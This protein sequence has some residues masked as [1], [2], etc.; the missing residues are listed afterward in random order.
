MLLIFMSAVFAFYMHAQSPSLNEV[1]SSDNQSFADEDGSFEDW[2]EIYNPSDQPVSLL[3]WYLSDDPSVPDKWQFPDVT[4]GAGAHL[5]VWAS[6]K[7]RRPPTRSPSALLT[8]IPDNAAW[9]YQDLGLPAPD[10]W[11]TIDFDD[12]DWSSGPGMLGY[13]CTSVN[14]TLS[15]GGVPDNKYITYYLRHTF[16]V[17]LENDEINDTG[18]FKLWADD[19]A[20][21]YLNGAEI[22]RV[23]IAPGNVN[24][25]TPASSVVA[26]RG[27][28]E[29]F[30]VSLAAIKTGTNV[31]SV[32][33]HQANAT[34]SDLCFW[35]ELLAYPSE[36]HTNF[37][38]SAGSEPVVLSD[39]DG[40]PIDQAPALT[41]IDDASMGRIS[42]DPA[43]E[44]VIFPRPTPG[45]P[46]SDTG[47]TGILSP[48]AVLRSPGVLQR[49]CFTESVS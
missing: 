32:E 8:L 42:D 39:P 10:L 49:P 41:L 27:L 11:T 23:R 34:S 30:N 7:D 19:G 48:P 33:M 15:Y 29:S 2:I 47:Y 9:R 45:A 12:S 18:I 35:C 28:W 37:K 31:I 16:E 3:N 44:W 5:Q 36:L 22:L 43:N 24:Y 26:S 38:I 40:L 21:V 46:N 1:M 17:S 6:G 25:L 13:N 20:I 14:T 4:I